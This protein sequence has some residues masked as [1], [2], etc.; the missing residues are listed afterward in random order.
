[1]ISVCPGEIGN[2]S[3]MTIPKGLESM[4]RSGG[5][6]QKGQGFMNGSLSTDF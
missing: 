5:S 4:M 2:P 1:M 6:V 3:R